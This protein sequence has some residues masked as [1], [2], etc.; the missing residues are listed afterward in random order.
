MKE[1]LKEI[2]IKALQ[3]GA[4]IGVD[5]Y[6]FCLEQ[7]PL[8]VA[9]LLKWNFFVSISWG[10][11]FILL[12]FVGFWS[13]NKFRILAEEHEKK[14]EKRLME[15][16][17]NS[18]K[19]E[20]TWSSFYCIMVIASSAISCISISFFFDAIKIHIAPRLFFLEYFNDFIK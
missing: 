1:N 18:W 9:E 5:L 6:Q 10:I 16:K 4:E 3:E 13:A 14:E 12:S 20:N 15:Q 17:G 11:V 19:Q 2:L 7:S 8:L